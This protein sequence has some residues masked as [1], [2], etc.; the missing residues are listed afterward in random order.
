[1][2][3]QDELSSLV[4]PLDRVR[5]GLLGLALGV[6]PIRYAMIDK[7]RRIALQSVALVVVATVVS[8]ALPVVPLLVSPLLLGVPHLASEARALL[9]RR[10]LPRPLLWTS[11]PFVVVLS[12][13]GA[14]TAFGGVDAVVSARIEIGVAALWMAVALARSPGARRL[15]VA[16][17]ALGLGATSLVLPL[18]A[19]AIRDLGVSVHAFVTVALWLAV[20]RSDKRY[21]VPL[22]AL[23]AIGL[24][25]VASVRGPLVGGAFLLNVHYAVWLILVPQDAAP[26]SGFSTFR[27]TA[28]GLVRDFGARGI[29]VV[30]ILSMLLLAFA[31][32]RGATVARDAYLAT[33]QFHVWAELA[34]GAF[35]L[36]GGRVAKPT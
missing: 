25:V 11:M 17:L 2:I 24:L 27:M 33:A 22:V 29:V 3:L 31:A 9:F 34:L 5:R 15:L 10:A 6:R 36:G 21:G 30:A 18:H 28:R 1:M 23:V 4:G 16:P 26:H 8:L 32:M 14:G 35:L 20:F 19:V 13:L 12:L 7:H